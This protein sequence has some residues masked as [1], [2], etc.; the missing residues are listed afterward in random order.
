MAEDKS[1]FSS[2]EEPESV[3]EGLVLLALC[4]LV[5]VMGLM[6][7]ALEATTA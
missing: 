4:F 2:G 5:A 1:P 3:L 6:V 7:V